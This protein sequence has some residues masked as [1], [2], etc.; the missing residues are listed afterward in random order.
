MNESSGRAESVAIWD[1]LRQTR[2]RA[3]LNRPRENQDIDAF[4]ATAQQRTRRRID[5]RA[6]GH[7]IVD[8]D[9]RAAFDPCSHPFGHLKRPLHIE[10]PLRTRKPDLGRR[11]LDPREGER[12]NGDAALGG[13][14][15]RQ[16]IGLI[17]P[18]GGKPAAMQ[19]DRHEEI[20][21]DEQT[22]PAP[23]RRRRA[24]PWHRWIGGN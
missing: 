22:E 7:D 11:R 8:K 21:L 15:L 13:D 10:S 19:R 9:N 1:R 20:G 17:E 4:G 2:R 18:A 5:G 12:I 6:R 14:R 3:L 16:G 24:S 23:N